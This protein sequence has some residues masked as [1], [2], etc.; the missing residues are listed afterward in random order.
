MFVG[1]R[2]RA[3][4]FPDVYYGLGPHSR[5]DDWEPFTRRTLEG[6]VVAEWPIGN[7]A[8]R[9][10]PRLDFRAEEVSEVEPGGALA[11][12]DVPGADGFRG[13]GAGASLT[14]DTRDGP[15]WPSRGAFAQAWYT[16]LS[17]RARRSRRARPRP[18]GGPQVRPARSGPRPRARRHRRVVARRRPVHDAAAARLDPL[19]ARHPRGPLPRPPRGGRP[20]RAAPAG[21]WPAVRYRVR[22]AGRGRTLAA[23]L[24]ARHDQ[25][26]RRGGPALAAHQRGREHPARPRRGAG[27]PRAVRARARGFLRAEMRVPEPFDLDLTVRSHGWYDLPPWRYDDAR[28]GA[29]RPLLLPGGADRPTPQVGGGARRPRVPRPRRGAARRGGR[30]RRPGRAPHL[31]LARRGPH[32]VL[33]ARGGARGAPRGR[34][35]ERSARPALG[36]RAGRGQAA[37]VADGVRGRGEDALHDELLV[38]AHARDGDAPVRRGSALPAPL[39]TRTFPTPEAMASQAGAPWTARR[40]AP[41]TAPRSSRVSRATSRP[42]RWTSR[43]SAPSDRADRTRSATRIRALAGFGPY[44]TEH[45]LRLLA[46]HDHLALDSW[47]RPKLA[48][49]QRRRVPT[50]RALRRRH[51]P[52]GAYAGLA[53]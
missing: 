37:P 41:A 51:A 48:Q 11:A 33:R 30:S 22:R 26:G 25:G 4:Y 15:F 43:H 32:R 13:A 50:D 18:R 31:P 24:R 36:D 47:T 21:P 6:Y 49:L 29:G 35:G 17:E 1:G 27:R 28:G 40:S 38:G 39:G 44:A 19:P 34:R 5:E 7:T 16:R 46:R 20:G 2:V 12:G 10:G 42:A 52:Y 14:Y 45:L 23:R 53:M 9:A 8:L 3:L